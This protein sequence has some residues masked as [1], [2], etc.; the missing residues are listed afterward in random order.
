MGLP[1]VALLGLKSR[2]REKWVCGDTYG[3]PA[4]PPFT[5]ALVERHFGAGAMILVCPITCGGC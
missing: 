2:V 1:K 4:P 3:D 5:A